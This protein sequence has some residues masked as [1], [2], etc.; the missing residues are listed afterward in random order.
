[1]DNAKRPLTYFKPTES[2]IAKIVD[3]TSV[4][5]TTFAS[6]NNEL[7]TEAAV[8]DVDWATATHQLSKLLIPSDRS[9]HSC[10]Y[11]ELADRRIKRERHSATGVPGAETSDRRQLRDRKSKASESIEVDNGGSMTVKPSATHRRRTIS[12]TPTLP[13]GGS[14]QPIPSIEVPLDTKV[15]PSDAV[16]AR[17]TIPRHPSSAAGPLKLPRTRDTSGTKAELAAVPPATRKPPVP[18]FPRRQSSDVG[19]RVDGLTTQV[20]KI[21]LKLSTSPAPTLP[22]PSSQAAIEVARKAATSKPRRALKEPVTAT[23]SAR[24]MSRSS[25]AP[26]TGA[27]SGSQEQVATNPAPMDISASHNVS[28][29]LIPHS[30]PTPATSSTVPTPFNS[31]SATTSPQ[32]LSSAPSSTSVA[33]IEVVVPPAISVPFKSSVSLD[34]H[35]R[36]PSYG[37]LAMQDIPHAAPNPSPFGPADARSYGPIASL[38]SS[39]ING[40][41]RERDRQSPLLAPLSETSKKDSPRKPKVRLPIFPANGHIPFAQ[42]QTQTQPSVT[43]A[44]NDMWEVPDTPHR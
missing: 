41:A 14:D 43:T 36:L 2:F 15:T 8:L 23:S 6:S 40:A 16:T 17:G 1:M 27:V 19:S 34:A 29:N 12:H 3:P 25:L 37:M 10:K 33:P 18:K 13:L 21:T 42:Q 28:V 7:D 39:S 38:A 32:P 20:K 31:S 26:M 9:V 5:K 35:S 44:I 30:V 24:R 11:E 22:P 4:Q